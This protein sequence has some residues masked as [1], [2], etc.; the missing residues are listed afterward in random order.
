MWRRRCWRL[1]RSWLQ[2]LPLRWARLQKAALS[3]NLLLLRLYRL[4][5]YLPLLFAML[6]QLLLLQQQEEQQQQL[7]QSF[8]QHQLLHPLGCTRRN[9]RQ[10]LAWWLKRERSMRV[11]QCLPVSGTCPRLQSR[12]V[13]SQRLR[14]LRAAALM[15]LL[16]VVYDR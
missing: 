9:R 10:L 12:S 11:P 15:L 5:L 7:L 13:K 1:Q 3:L 2:L 14:L 4:L 8:E 16:L 6:L